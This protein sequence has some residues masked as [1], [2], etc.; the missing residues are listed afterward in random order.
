MSLPKLWI[1]RIFAK[2]T[3]N[4]G[5]DFLRRWEGIDL[6]LVQDDW[7]HELSSYEKAPHAIA[8]ALQNLPAK[9][10]TV[11]EFRAIA[12]RAP[13]PLEAALDAPRA[14][15]DVV[16]KAI[17]EARALL[18]GRT[19]ALQRPAPLGRYRH[20]GDDDPDVASPNVAGTSAAL[21]PNSKAGVEAL[22]VARGLGKWDELK[23][24][25]TAYK[26]R[27]LAAPDLGA[28]DD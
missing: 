25:F 17:A 11:L 3:M 22:G 6:L 1:D 9:P 15:P 13:V 12:Q 10:P 4:Y 7:A 5:H 21:D 14:S 18:A 28:R 20:H 16:R 8:Y 23:E 19:P 2:L 27:V 26:A 24:Q